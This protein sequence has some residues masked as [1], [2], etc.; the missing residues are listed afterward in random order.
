MPCVPS[1]SLMMTDAPP[2]VSMTS[3]ANFEERN[4][5]CALCLCH[6]VLSHLAHTASSTTDRASRRKQRYSVVAR[7]FP[8]HYH[9]C[10]PPG[11][12]LYGCAADGIGEGEGDEPFHPDISETGLGRLYGAKHPWRGP[13]NVGNGLYSP[14]SP[15]FLG[16]E[17][18]ALWTGIGCSGN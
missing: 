1:R 13:R 8:C 6:P 3:S 12:R 10:S 16:W 5:R 11:N 2:T 18:C 9:S 15:W 7:R 4:R 14:P 17:S